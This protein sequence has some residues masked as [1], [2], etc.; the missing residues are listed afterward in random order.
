MR[1]Q[2]RF[3]LVWAIAL[4]AGGIALA[5]LG[6]YGVHVVAFGL[7]YAALATS[8]S[9]LRATGLFSFG[10]AAFFGAGALTEAWLV[11][12]GR[13]SPWLALCA[14]AAV[15]ALA[16]VPLIPGL[17]LAPASFGLATLAYAV[18]LKGLA[19]NAPA[20]GMEGF[21][22]PKTPGFDGPAAPVVVIL[23]GLV[24]AVSFGYEVFLRRPSGRAAAALRQSPETTLSL[25]I[26]L[27]GARWRPLTLSAATTAVAGALYAHLVGSVE[28]TVVFSTTFSVVPLV[29]GVIG[30][31]LNPLGGLVGTLAL[32]P[33]DELLF[34]PAFPQAHV[35]VYGLALCGLLLFRPEGLLGARTP[36]IPVCASLRRIAHGPWPLTV[37]G[38]TV[39]RSGTTVLRDV[40]F[41]VEPGKIL[42]ILGPNGAGKTSLLLAIAGRIPGARGAVFLGGTACPRGT[43]ARARRGLGRT[44]QAPRPFP[45]WTVRENVALAAERGGA[46]GEV[47]KL[48]QELDLCELS[49]RPAGQLSVGEGKRLE[50]ARA[51]ALAP[52][53]LLL[54]E[55]LAGLSPVAAEQVSNV[56]ERKRREGVAIVWVE[57]G[58]A[59]G[60]LASQLLVLESGRIRFLGSPGDWEAARGVPS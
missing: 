51:L 22:L 35:L 14:S 12:A 5:T 13:A 58:P 34:R 55:P 38:L 18:L 29:L 26:D 15:G 36:R 40:S 41:A 54:D 7:L 17:R 25:G 8:W 2:R 3:A 48:L 39:R 9:C 16:A 33:L 37:R 56:I 45:E 52:S 11:A 53:L 46:P 19:S 30:G 49:D 47:E 6:R 42:R 57:H 44:F 27:V 32:Y 20:F 43:A 59:A 50:L 10:Q 23:A 31:A 28:T 60:D 24:L 21:L 4:L 1:E